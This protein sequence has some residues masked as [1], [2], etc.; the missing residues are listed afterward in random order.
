MAKKRKKKHNKGGQFEREMAVAFSEWW[1][2]DKNPDIFWRTHGSGARATTRQRRG[3]RTDGQ[4]GD[5]CA[6][7]PEGRLFLKVFTVS[8]KR[9]QHMGTTIQDLIDMPARIKERKFERWIEEAVEQAG[10]A[11]SLSWLIVFRRDQ[12]RA[13]V[14]LPKE[15]WKQI[16]KNLVP[17]CRISLASFPPLVVVPLTT[18]FNVAEPK[19]IRQIA[20]HA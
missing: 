11:E 15:M 13:I 18:F 5:L 10:F 16:S 14:I 3:I 19:H 12:K 17:E 20:E 4:Y 7:D 6:N 9:G 1:T 8:L 2:W